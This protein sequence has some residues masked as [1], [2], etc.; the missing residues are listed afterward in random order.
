[1]EFSAEKFQQNALKNFFGE[2]NKLC[3]SK[4]GVYSAIPRVAVSLDANYIFWHIASMLAKASGPT[5]Y[6]RHDDYPVPTLVPDLILAI[7]G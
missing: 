4:T 2:D 5:I 3:S 6:N 7:S 1:M